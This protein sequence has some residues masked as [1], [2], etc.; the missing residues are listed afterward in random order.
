M[1]NPNHNKQYEVQNIDDFIKQFCKLKLG[2]LERISDVDQEVP[3][4]VLLLNNHTRIALEACLVFANDEKPDS[5]PISH[6][7]YNPNPAIDELFKIVER[8]S[9][10][11][12]TLEDT[13]ETWLLVSAGSYISDHD[14]AS[15]LNEL[16]R[17]NFDRIFIHKGTGGK[18]LEIK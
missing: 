8:K 2:T 16:K 18:L 10:T 17:N 9:L 4:A 3:D 13:Q 14:L 1:S 12:Y 15:R 11:N 7:A 5:L 6:S